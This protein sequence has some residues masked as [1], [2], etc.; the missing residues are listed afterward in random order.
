MNIDFDNISGDSEEVSKFKSIFSKIEE[1][2]EQKREKAFERGETYI[3]ASDYNIW[4]IWENKDKSI[5]LTYGD[6][7]IIAKY[8]SELKDSHLKEAVYE[9]SLRNIE[10]EFCK[11][12]KLD[13]NRCI[14]RDYIHMLKRR[15]G[16]FN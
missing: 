7:L 2:N 3:E 15:L 5:N 16:I 6:L 4:T 9:M 10:N 12:C 14:M 13:C 8:I 1:E 11:E